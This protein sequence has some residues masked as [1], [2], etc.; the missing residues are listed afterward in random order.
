MSTKQAERI[1]TV[2][3]NPYKSHNYWEIAR[4]KANIDYSMKPRLRD[5]KANQEEP[6]ALAQ[7]TASG[8]LGR[9]GMGV[10]PAPWLLAQK[11]IDV[12]GI[13]D[14]A[15]TAQ[16]HN[17]SR[18]FAHAMASLTWQDPLALVMDGHLPDLRLSG[19]LGRNS[20][21]PWLFPWLK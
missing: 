18:E 6:A 2:G 13:C 7:W 5:W 19:L 3:T 17:G 20:L 11:L 21:A 8:W 10:G 1:G 4:G 16:W 9:A 14:I 15:V 12:D